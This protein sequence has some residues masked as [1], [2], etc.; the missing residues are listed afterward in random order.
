MVVCPAFSANW[1][2]YA[3]YCRAVSGQLRAI[4]KG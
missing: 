3:P 4:K 2:I 1:L